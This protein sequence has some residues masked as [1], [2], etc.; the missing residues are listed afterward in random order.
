[1]EKIEYLWKSLADFLWGDWLLLALLGLGALYTVITG[2]IQFKCIKLCRQGFFSFAKKP[3]DVQDEKKC[4]SYQALCAAVAS[5]VGSG[6][7]VGVSTAILSG[8][9]GALFWMW[10]AA[11]LGMATK[12]GEIVMG[13]KYH[14]QDEQGNISGGPMYY[15]EYGM[16]WKWAGILVAVLL[17]I[18][19]SGATLIQSN[20][21]SNV[22]HESFR[23]P[24]LL[25]GCMLAVLMSLVIRGG[26]KRLVHVAQRI[27]PVMAGIYVAGG[28]MVLLLHM[29]QIPAMLASIIKEAFSL[30]A[31]TGALAGITIKEAMR[32]GV[33][34]GLYS[35][36]AGEGSAAVLHSSA[37]VDHPVRQGMYGVVE[38]FI[39][40]MLISSTT[41]F[42][43][44]ITGANGFHENA[45]TLAAAAFRSAFPGMQYIIYISLILFA[46]T[47]LMSQWYFG[48]VS[49]TYL[50]KPGLAVAYR[51]LFPL[52]IVLG[53]LG[54][55]EMVWYIQDCALGL[56]ILPNIAALV[57]LAPQ[58]RRLTK[59]FM[60]PD[61]GYLK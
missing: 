9:P 60:D 12:F 15:I 5:C 42:T 27:V 51:Y 17:F 34:R 32:F 2:G 43:V 4:S 21:V 41:G 7:I 33:A 28:L 45:S 31:G 24:F 52:M 26:F 58:V 55:I 22:V 53:S 48:H 46:S 40:T 3:E 44:L 54:S 16:H 57:C 25:T 14:G 50:K 47:S 20:T 23:V 59:E 56:L 11:F 29:G 38:V 10:A 49:L 8:G 37:E 30:K 61:K 35:N 19:N 13:V 36:E 39:D 6:N 1:M 18:Q